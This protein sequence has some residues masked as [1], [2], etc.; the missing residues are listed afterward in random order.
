MP[1]SSMAAL[2]ARVRLM[3]FDTASPQLFTDDNIQDKL[4]D[5][6]V[7]RDIVE[8]PLVPRPTYTKSGA[9]IQWNDYYFIPSLDPS[10]P[11]RGNWEDSVA[12]IW[13]DFSP[14]TPA[15]SELILGHWTFNNQLPTIFIKGSRYDV[16][17]AAA[18][19]LDYKVA[20]LAATQ[21]DFT[22]DGQSFH[23]SQQLTFLQ[24]TSGDYRRKQEARI[25]AHGRSDAQSERGVGLAP[26]QAELAGPVSANVPFLTG[27]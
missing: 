15:T 20:A 12:L 21:I 13:T 9:S 4:D 26:N 6:Q 11:P 27:N 24:K 16:Y 22:A 14:L 23:L 8:F 7:R 5:P 2:I 3:I 17:R 25:G 18:D 19:L 1:R 10:D